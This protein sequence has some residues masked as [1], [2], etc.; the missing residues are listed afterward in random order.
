MAMSSSAAVASTEGHG[1][2][3]FGVGSEIAAHAFDGLFFVR[4]GADLNLRDGDGMYLQA[5]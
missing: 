1:S 5:M 2:A 4:H 3:C